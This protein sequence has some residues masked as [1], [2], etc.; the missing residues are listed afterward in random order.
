MTS[1]SR[2]LVVDDD[3]DLRQLLQAYLGK[4]GYEVRALP[5]ALQLEKTMERFAPHMVVLD[6]MMPG[7]DGISACRRLRADCT[8]CG[9][10]RNAVR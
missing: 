7:E 9:L 10:M 4:H 5:D 2:I 1:A 6:W 3:A 8:S